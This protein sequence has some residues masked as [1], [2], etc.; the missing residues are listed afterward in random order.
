VHEA[1]KI[2]QNAIEE[3]HSTTED[4]RVTIANASLA[5]HRGDTKLALEFL[6]SI[7][8]SQTYYQQARCKKAYIH[9]NP[10]K[11]RSAFTECFREMAES[12]PSP[13]SFMMHICL[14]RNQTELLKLMN[15]L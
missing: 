11:D 6:Q 10:H 14:F 13:Q 9:L 3:F 2:M 5:L 12:S 7:G 1:A 15:R 8:P 4:G